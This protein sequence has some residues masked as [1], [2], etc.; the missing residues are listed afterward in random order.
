MLLVTWEHKGMHWQP[1]PEE[2]VHHALAAYAFE[3]QL[4]LLETGDRRL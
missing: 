3:I 4:P 1:Q 2:V